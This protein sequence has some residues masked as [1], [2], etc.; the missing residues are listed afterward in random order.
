MFH[1]VV[2]TAA[3]RL[4][5]QRLS[6]PPYQQAIDRLFAAYIGWREESDAVQEAYSRYDT[7]RRHRPGHAFAVY[8]AALD[9]E[10]RAAAEY[11]AC[12]QEVCALVSEAGESS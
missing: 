7:S 11:A 3:R 1:N 12:V 2:D 5:W 6:E 4:G 8:F 9:R 10:E